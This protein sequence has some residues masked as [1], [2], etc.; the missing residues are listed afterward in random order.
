MLQIN[1]PNRPNMANCQKGSEPDE[2]K[3]APKVG[4]KKVRYVIGSKIINLVLVAMESAI[5]IRA[6]TLKVTP[7]SHKSNLESLVRMS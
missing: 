5:A 1:P 2:P 7:N 6:G 3:I 4:M